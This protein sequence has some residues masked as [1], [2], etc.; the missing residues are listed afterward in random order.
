MSGSLMEIIYASVITTLGVISVASGFEGFLFG[1]IRSIW[2]RILL[3][4]GGFIFI[5]PAMWSDIAGFAILAAIICWQKI[6]RKNN[7]DPA[8]RDQGQEA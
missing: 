2:L 3:C 1:P 8:L 6:I 5:L 4:L 7:P